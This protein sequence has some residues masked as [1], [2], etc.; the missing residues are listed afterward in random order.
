MRQVRVQV[1]EDMSTHSRYCA[2]KQDAFHPY[3]RMSAEEFRRRTAAGFAAWRTGGRPETSS[4]AS[5]RHH[6]RCAATRDWQRRE[7]AWNRSW[8]ALVRQQTPEQAAER[9]RELEAAARKLA[10]GGRIAGSA[11]IHQAEST[12]LVSSRSEVPL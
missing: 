1:S 5:A 8:P 4:S 12:E 10:T 11:R 3:G 9:R 6:R 7:R 2:E